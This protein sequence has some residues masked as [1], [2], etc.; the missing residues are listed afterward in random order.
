MDY[1]K[2]KMRSNYRYNR[3][4]DHSMAQIIAARTLLITLFYNNVIINRRIFCIGENR[5]F[6][7][8]QDGSF[9]FLPRS[10]LSMKYVSTEFDHCDRLV[11]S[12]LGR[13]EIAEM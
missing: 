6:N 1:G 7:I 10:L 5:N 2:C 12:R 13:I 11:L 8:I 9:E 4:Y 3:D